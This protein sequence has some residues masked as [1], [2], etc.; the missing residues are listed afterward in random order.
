MDYLINRDWLINMSV[1]YMDIDT[2]ANYK[3]AG[4]QQ[5]DSIRLDRGCLC[6]LPDTG[7][8]V[9]GKAG[10]NDQLY[11]VDAKSVAAIADASFAASTP[12]TSASTATHYPIYSGI[13][14]YHRCAAD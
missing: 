1:W 10:R 7:S 4:A 3:L 14:R 8:K 12:G 5:H 11:Y 6:S 9:S 13:P 2:T